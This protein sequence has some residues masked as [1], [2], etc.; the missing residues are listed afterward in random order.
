[1][2][3]LTLVVWGAA[4][5]LVITWYIQQ[6]TNIDSYTDADESIYIHT[7]TEIVSEMEIF[8]LY[9]CAYL[10][11]TYV[12][13]LHSTHKTLHDMLCEMIYSQHIEGILQF[14]IIPRAY[15]VHYTHLRLCVSVCVCK[16]VTYLS[17]ALIDGCCILAVHL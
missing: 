14:H 7:W 12:C 5:I 16:Q 13:R 2:L 9:T 10:E 3:L 15:H 17:I 4:G 8:C 1:M 6:Q 11:C